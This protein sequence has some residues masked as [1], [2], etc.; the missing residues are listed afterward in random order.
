MDSVKGDI[1][2]MVSLPDY[3]PNIWIPKIS[4][5]DFNYFNDADSTPAI[6]RATYARYAPGSIFKILISLSGLNSGLIDPEER[7]VTQVYHPYGIKDLAPAGY[8]NFQEAF[9]RSSNYYLIECGLEMGAREII[10]TS[11]LFGLGNRTGIEGIPPSQELEGRIPNYNR[12][13]SNW[14]RGDTANLSI[15]QGEIDVTLLQMSL[16]TSAVANGGK[17]LK[18]RLVQ[19]LEF[20]SPVEGRLIFKHYSPEV[21]RELGYSNESLQIVQDAMRADVADSRFGTGKRAAVVGMEIHGKTGTAETTRNGK[22]TKN[23]WFVSYCPYLGRLF[24]VAIV[25]E[26]TTEADFGSTV[27][28]PVAKSIYLAIR[29]RMSMH[30]KY[31]QP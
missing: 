27:C 25:I 31:S 14:Y 8:Y 2:A 18:P 16:M 23:V 30:E 26:A 9:A 5:E 7:M 19:A 20:Q 24:T 10:D 21:V 4:T 6:N 13:Q 17:L 22:A 12:I 15:G 3:D 11:R 29:D 1:L 28:A